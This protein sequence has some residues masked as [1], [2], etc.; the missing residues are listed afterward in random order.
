MLSNHFL[1]HA[2]A[3]F[4]LPLIFNGTL[5]ARFSVE[6]VIVVFEN[7]ADVQVL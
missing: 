6:R 7:A 1:Y 3:D 2:I 5:S 4:I